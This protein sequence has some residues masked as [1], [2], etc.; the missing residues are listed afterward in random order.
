MYQVGCL[1]MIK[2]VF[3]KDLEKKR[4]VDLFKEVF[5]IEVYDVIDDLDVDVVIEVIGGVEQIK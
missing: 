2:K 3:V 5:M 4:E 1:I